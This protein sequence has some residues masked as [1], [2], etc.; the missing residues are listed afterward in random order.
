VAVLSTQ[1]WHHTF[2][3]SSLCE[4]P[5]LEWRALRPAIAAM[6]SAYVA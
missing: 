2:L 6:P 1:L 5:G 3:D 4:L